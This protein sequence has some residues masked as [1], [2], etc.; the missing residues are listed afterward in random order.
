MLTPSQM[1]IL[2]A[3]HAA[4]T[5]AEKAKA[6]IAAEQK[7]RKEAFAAIF[8]QP[9][10][11]TNKLDM[12]EGWTLKATY[13]LDRKVDARVVESLRAPLRAEHVSLD[14]LIEWKPQ[15]KTKEYRELPEAARKIFDACLTTKPASPTLE[16]VAPKV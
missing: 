2:G 3:W 5:A 13:S 8:S 7:L 1:E 15:L 16:L 11:G 14:S 10:E 4:S 6:V 12:P 9:E